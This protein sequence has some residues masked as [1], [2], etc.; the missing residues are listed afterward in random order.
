MVWKG[1]MLTTTTD[2]I[3]KIG[4]ILFTTLTVYLKLKKTWQK[5]HAYKSLYLP[6][7]FYFHY[8][9]VLCSHVTILVILSGIYFLRRG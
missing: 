7:I 1:L 8:F 4:I 5:Y 6:L 9:S 2:N 3:F